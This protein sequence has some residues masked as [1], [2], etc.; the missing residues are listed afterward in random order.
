[1]DLSEYS[2]NDG[3]EIEGLFTEVF[4]MSEG[5]S[6]GLLIGK[7]AHDLM[8]STDSK[9]LYGFVARENG[10]IVGCIFYSRATFESEVNAFIL[11]PV[12]IRTDY[13]GQGIGQNLINFG[14]NCLKE[15][16]VSLVFTYGDPDYY[17]KVGFRPVS[18]QVIKAPLAL[19]YPFGWLCNS[20]SG[21]EIEAIAGNSYCVDALNNPEYW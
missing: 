20:L 7:L 18:E 1:M 9:D 4:S 8:N 16:G 6:E 12:A 10:R 13:Q 2:S 17:K 5:L 21:G 11:S 15:K 19:K 3:E 14:N